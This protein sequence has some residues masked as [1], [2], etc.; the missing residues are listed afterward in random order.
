MD[1]EKGASEMVQTSLPMGSG[2]IPPWPDGGTAGVLDQRGQI[3][4]APDP[5]RTA[6]RTDWKWAAVIP[7]RNESATLQTILAELERLSLYQI[8]V[9]VNGSTDATRAIA[10]HYGC[11]VLEFS[12]A[13]GHDVGRGLGAQASDRTDGVVFL[14]ADIE[15]R[16]GELVSFLTAVEGGMDVALNDVN[17]LPLFNPRHPV[18]VAKAYL[19]VVLD[20]T[21]LGSSSMTGVPHALSRKALDVIGCEALAVP[22]MAQAKAILSHLRVGL[23]SAVDVVGR[24]RIHGADSP[25]TSGQL[26]DLIVGDHLEAISYVLSERGVRG[27][28]SDG[29][30]QRQRFTQAEPPPADD[31]P[32]IRAVV[33]HGGYQDVKVSGTVQ[34][35]K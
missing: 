29:N 5:P 27:G 7:A 6:R 13:L 33:P 14:D 20:R 18:N 21:D 15:F 1:K 2:L 4:L 28:F 32:A 30:R 9:V 25:V 8:V 24:N 31:R 34:R 12:G 3:V 19:N 26:E 16:A 22:P 23:A 11:K 35:L 17:Q 10:M